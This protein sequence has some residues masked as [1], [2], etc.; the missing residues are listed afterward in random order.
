MGL[1]RK[2]VFL[3][4]GLS[5]GL[6]APTLAAGSGV[7]PWAQGDVSLLVSQGFLKGNT[8]GDLFLQSPISRA[9]AAVLLGR[10]LGV[11]GTSKVLAGYQDSS[12][13]PSW[14]VHRMAGLVQDKILQGEGSLL[15]P[16]QNLSRA[17]AT[18]LLARVAKLKSSN[19]AAPFSDL[20]SVPKWAVGYVNAA[21]QAGLVQGTGSNF[22]PSAPITRAAFAV[23]L[24]RT[25]AHLG[26]STI[27]GATSPLS[28]A[29]VVGQVVAPNLSQLVV[30]GNGAGTYGGVLLGAHVGSQTLY[31]FAQGS[32]IYRNERSSTLYGLTPG[33]RVVLVLGKHGAI[34]LADDVTLHKPQGAQ[35][36]GIVSNLDATTLWLSNGRVY[37]FIGNLSVSYQGRLLAIS[38]PY[39]QLVGADVQPL[40]KNGKIAALVLK[41]PYTRDLSGTVSSTSSVGFTMSITRTD[42]SL[43]NAALTAGSNLTVQITKDTAIENSSQATGVAVGDHVDVIGSYNGSSVTATAVLIGP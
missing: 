9:E 1:S 14:A 32:S 43:Y 17:Q 10:L 25:E 26:N 37:P 6:A 42:L 18:V 2:M 24:A 7:P 16:K 36:H 33:D 31:K 8:H 15:A 27:P 21:Y 19:Q 22:A 12:S 34:S 39:S 40:M 23:L 29:G 5:L 41:T 11:Q 20:A 13:V 28:V 35:P 30:Q 38:A 3:T 4:V